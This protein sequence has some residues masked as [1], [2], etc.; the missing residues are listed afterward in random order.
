M[1]VP[2][3]AATAG[4]IGADWLLE[5]IAPNGAFGRAAREREQAFRRGDE[6]A[7]RAALARVARIARDVP[8]PLLGELRAALAAAPDVRAALARACEGA[9]LD[10]VDFFEIARFIDTLD[11]VARRT[12]GDAF[13]PHDVACADPALRDALA[14]ARTPARTF[15]LADLF[16]SKLAARRG[17]AANAQAAYD[18]ARGRTYARVA[19]ALGRETLGEDVFTVMRDALPAP[20]PAGLRVLR[21]APTY[22]LCA[23]ELDEAAL[24]ALASRETAVAAVAEAEEAVRVTLSRNVARAA[25]RL[26]A[27]CDAL[28]NLESLLARAAFAQRYAGVVPTLVDAPA[29]TLDEVRYVPLADALALR[30]GRYAPLSFALFGVGVVTGP[31]MGGKTAALRALGFAAACVALG[32]PVPARAATLPLVDEIAWLGSE[33]LPHD[34]A[35]L[36]AF[37]SEV[38]EL[39]AFMDRGAAP[40]LVLLDEF[41][42]ATAP[43]EG[44][45]LLVALLE[46]LRLRGAVGL[47]ATH[48]TGIAADAHVPHYAVGGLRELTSPQG[49]RLELDVAL[50]GIARATDYGLAR[51]DERALPA[52]DALALAEALG[53]DPTLLARARAML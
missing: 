14:P 18:A 8:A 26:N 23:L 51:V 49:A 9:T 5:A 1:T 12:T 30:G 45:A 53:L 19:R 3:N 16:D 33:T 35:L 42:R 46:T 50:A 13:E 22:L 4:A 27:A 40:A 25:A 17:E 21:E 39:R 29:V 2:W 52:A 48:F 43:R 47:A 28:G 32:V 20:W 41:A 34:D 24:A 36:S 38:V 7:A 6:A 31:N 44:R 37:G 11:D 15:Y 10:D